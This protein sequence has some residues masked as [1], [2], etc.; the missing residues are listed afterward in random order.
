MVMSHTIQASYSK[1]RTDD[2]TADDVAFDGSTS[3][4]RY[5]DITTRD[6]FIY[7]PATNG[8]SIF[9]SAEATEGATFGAEIWNITN[10]GLA[11]KCADITGAAGSAWADMTNADSTARL[12]MDTITI[13]EEFHLKEVT[14]ADSGNNR[15][16]KIG[17]DTLGGRGG[18]VSFH[19]IGGANEVKRITPW[20][21]FF[22]IVVG[23]FSLF[24]LGL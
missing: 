3:G 24:V 19:S 7:D 16:A 9:F 22:T 12:F 21:R 11:E 8:V 10:D 6:V 1:M 18:Y 2:V 20:V 5:T 17:M 14:V 15:Y 13:S 4:A 23:F